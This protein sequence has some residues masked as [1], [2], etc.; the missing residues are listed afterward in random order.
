MTT[1]E[2][3]S[4]LSRMSISEIAYQIYKDKLN[5]SGKKINYAAA[6]Y[7]DAMVSLNSVNERYGM[8]S[9]RSVVNYFLCNAATWK[10]E[11]AKA[12]KAELKKRV[13]QK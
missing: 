5:W 9:G 12:I 11:T 8:D 7:L 3:K 2:L 6:P 4:S 10:G 13:N 1:E